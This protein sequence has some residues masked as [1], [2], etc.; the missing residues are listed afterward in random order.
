MKLLTTN[1]LVKNA[2]GLIGALVL[3]VCSFSSYAGV[4]NV[5]SYG[6]THDQTLTGNEFI[7]DGIQVTSSDRI[8]TACG[9]LC[10][11]V[12]D[13]TEGWA[14]GESVFNFVLASG[15]NAA[16]NSFSFDAVIG[17]LFY[18]VFD[19]DNNV[20]ASGFGDYSY[21][22]ATA[23]SYFTVDYNYDGIYS[24]TWDNMSAVS[25]AAVSEPSVF[26][27][28]LMGLLGLGVSRRK[29]NRI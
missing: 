13:A 18:Q 12:D 6:F 28:M 7:A 2:A 23:I 5:G 14:F 10:T 4:I 9:G 16:V 20:F 27:L 8:M 3:S 11:S 1:R 19:V 25:A 26:V 15:A 24:I 17:S 21:A 22:G 29:A